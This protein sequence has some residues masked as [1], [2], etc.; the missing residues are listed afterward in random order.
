MMLKKAPERY[1]SARFTAAND[2]EEVDKSCGLRSERSRKD[3]V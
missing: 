1:A 3:V 2:G